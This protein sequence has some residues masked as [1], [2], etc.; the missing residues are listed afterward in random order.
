MD[1]TLVAAGNL[2]RALC[3]AW[4]DQYSF[5]EIGSDVEKIRLLNEARDL[6]V[7]TGYVAPED[8]RALYQGVYLR[9]VWDSR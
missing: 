2:L 9:D 1:A 3:E 4:A 6:L 7:G 8:V 5:N